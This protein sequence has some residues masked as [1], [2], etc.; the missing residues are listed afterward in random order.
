MKVAIT[1]IGLVC[2]AGVGLDEVLARLKAG[3]IEPQDP[4]EPRGPGRVDAQ[5]LSVPATFKPKE[6]VKR[7][8][9]LKLMAR[10]NRLAVAAARLAVDDAGLAEADWSDAALYLGVG[11]EPGSHVD[12]VPPVAHSLVEGALDLDR[13][14]AEGM[15]W[16]SPLSSLKTLPNMSVAH[17]AITLGTMGPTMA[18]CAGSE[19]GPRAIYEAALAVA[20]GD[21]PLAIAGAAD[22]R[23]EFGERVTATRLGIPVVGE[24]AALFVLEPESIALA[25]GAHI[26]GLI[27][28]HDG[29]PEHPDLFGECGAVRAVAG[30]ALALAQGQPAAH[31]AAAIR[32]Q[33]PAIRTTT[34]RDPVVISGVGLRTPLGA[35]F[36]GFTQA[37]LNGTCAT[38]SIQAF[39]ATRFPVKNAC[40]VPNFDPRELPDA[41][42]A[43]IDGIDDRKSEL[44]LAAALAA[45]KDHGGLSTKAGLVYATGLSSVSMTELA[46]DWTPF[47]GA[48]DRLNFAAFNAGE[49]PARPQSPY[50]HQVD[51]PVHLLRDH[52]GLT[53]PTACH[54]SACA[55]GSAAVAHAADLIRRGDAEVMLVGGADSMV[56]PFG[57]LPFIRLGATT[58]EPDASKAGRP[59]DAQRDGFVMGEGSAFF[60][61]EPLSR[62]RAAG[63]RIYGILQG[64]GTS[65]D[66]FNVTAPH[67]EGAGAIRAIKNALRDADLP[68][69]AI[70]YINAHGTGTALNDVIEA[71]AIRAVFGE[72]T[73]P[74]S[75]SKGQFGHG[76]AAA[77]SLELLAVLAAF[78]GQKLPPNPR[79]QIPDPQVDLHLVGP[80]GEPTPI[81]FAM[82]NSFGF[83][84]Q[85]A[86]LVIGHPDGVR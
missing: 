65:C 66:A 3:P 27:S 6:W 46:Q 20:R 19:S 51:R 52:L 47:I 85:N 70:D 54:F 61:L 58:T 22:D 64:A 37:L 57:L 74:V 71:K 26:Y 48:D 5:V 59:F 80:I 76:I 79:L 2:P 62:A 31:G 28:A 67:P 86:C 18:L 63:R 82:S 40:E 12:L 23:T 21:A 35:H 53:G 9:D 55:A 29:P 16:M 75:S 33:A 24:G 13:L 15:N 32:P 36:D 38:A 7:R 10:S 43:A 81:Q 45:I 49:T 30:M 44:G 34:R 14:V 83:G 56:H 73:P 84:G 60:I 42:F 41:L 1:G 72:S 68:P 25:R 77:G 50:R 4:K 8:K 17:V 11:R 69:K 78:A 39:D